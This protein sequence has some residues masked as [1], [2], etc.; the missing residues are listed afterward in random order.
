MVAFL[1]VTLFRAVFKHVTGVTPG[2]QAE[3]FEGAQ[4][5]VLPNPSGRN[6]ETPWD[7]RKMLGSFRVLA[8]RAARLRRTSGG[9]S[10][11]G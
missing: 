6:A 8:R 2:L 3:R 10:P 5:F 9:T 4:V 1:G 11:A 7:A